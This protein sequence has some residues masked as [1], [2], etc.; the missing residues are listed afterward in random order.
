M[1]LF[2]VVRLDVEVVILVV[3]LAGV[4]LVALFA[5]LEDVRDAVLLKVVPLDVVMLVPLAVSP[6]VLLDAL[7]VPR[8]AGPR[9]VRRDG[10]RP[11]RS[12]RI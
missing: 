11:R 9:R 6:A 7:L 8:E 3:L 4:L 2:N 10:R 5:Q 12:R 1:A